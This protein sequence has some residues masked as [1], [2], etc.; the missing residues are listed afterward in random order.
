MAVL[1]KIA[2]FLGIYE[3]V[4]GVEREEI[5]S[6]LFRERL[7]KYVMPTA[8]DEELELFLCD[9]NTVGFGFR[10]YPKAGIGQDT[11]TI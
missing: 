3:E 1:R 9:D 6:L 4:S 7:S 8:F 5:E 10:L 11:V 2:E